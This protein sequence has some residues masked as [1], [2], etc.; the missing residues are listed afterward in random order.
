MKTFLSIYTIRI[1]KYTN[2]I[3]KKKQANYCKKLSEFDGYNDI[4]DVINTFLKEV[5]SG[6]T[7]DTYKMYIKSI[8]VQQ[9][10]RSIS[11]IIESGVYG[12]AS[13]IRDVQTDKTNYKKQK[14]DAD[15]LPFYFLFYLPKDTDEGLLI[16][17]RTGVFGIRSSFGSFLDKYFS[18]K[19]S[20]YCI[21]I[22]TLINEEVI[23]KI[24]SN[25]NI[26]K[27]RCVKYSATSDSIDGLDEGHEET[28]F[29]MEVVLSANRIPLWHKVQSFFDSKSDVKKLIEIRDFKFDYDTVKIEVEIN[30]SV[31][32]FDLGN[33]G[34]AKASYDISDRIIMDS[35]EHPNFD[36]IHKVA[37]EYMSEIIDQIYP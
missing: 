22:N 26:Q 18:K 2:K 19:Y 34:K 32:I 5:E 28:A 10:G 24:I 1:K 36:S 7:N 8:R 30:G 16:L 35:D 31:R 6:N 15:V 13:E 25:G 20:S 17:Q 14:N 4:Y 11:G 21:E 29:N 37:E 3:D 9:H 12:I 23:K 33:L 27:L